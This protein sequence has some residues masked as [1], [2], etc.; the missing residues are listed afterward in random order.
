MPGFGIRFRNGGPGVFFIKY[1]LGGKHGRLSLGKVSKV[2]L[3]DAQATAKRHFAM[4]AEKVDPAIERARA[5]AKAS[6]TIE[7]LIGDFVRYLRR[8]GRAD[9][10]LAESSDRY[11]AISARCSASRPPT[12]P[13]PWSQSSWRQSEPNAAR[14]RLT[15]SRAH[16]SKFFAWMI[17][18][19]HADTN[20]VSGTNRTGGKPRDRLLQDAEL[21]SILGVLG[22]DDYGDIIRLL[23]SDRR[24]A[25]R[26]RRTASHRSQFLTKA[27]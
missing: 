20:P 9:S 3:A 14:A 10:Y 7:P 15:G 16:L 12:S 18:E 1:K 13:A 6:D 5:V 25:R 4:I 19:G 23:I 11:A 26:N 27:D 21:A 2:T 17:A 8:N 24:E 22:S